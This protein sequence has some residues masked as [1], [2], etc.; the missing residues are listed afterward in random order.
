VCGAAGALSAGAALL[1]C[2]GG[3]LG[4]AVAGKAAT[5][6]ATGGDP[7][8][9]D[10]YT[11]SGDLTLM[12]VTAGTTGGLADAGAAGAALA[13]GAASTGTV[14]DSVVPK[15]PL[16]G[17]TPVPKSFALTV[18][19]TEVWVHPNATEHIFDDLRGVVDRGASCQTIDLAAQSR[20]ASLQAAVAEASGG[21]T[22]P[23]GQMIKVGGWELKF[24]NPAASGM[25]PVLY[26]AR[27]VGG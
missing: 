4:I 19:D 21:G 10:A 23:I 13:G 6:A 17:G 24:G 1:V 2:I 8:A 3:G 18:G 16:H 12:L 20:L 22:P 26:H 25:L 27:Y 9:A 11:V 15:Q 7:A 5:S 14:W